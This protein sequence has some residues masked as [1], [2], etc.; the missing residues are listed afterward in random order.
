MSGVDEAGRL[1]RSVWIEGSHNP[2][3]REGKILRGDA[4]RRRQSVESRRVV[5][6]IPLDV[7]EGFAYGLVVEE[8]KYLVPP[9]RPADAS[10]ELVELIGVLRHGK[11]RAVESLVCVEARFVVRKEETAVEVV[12]AALGS[13]LNLGAAETAILGIVAVGNDFYALNGIFGRR[14][15]RCTAPDGTCGANAV[16]RNAIVFRLLT[17]GDDLCAVFGFKDAVRATGLPAACLC[18]WKIITVTSASTLRAI[19]EGSRSK[20][21]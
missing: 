19:R 21:R 16:D 15:D 14:D 3:A 18:A 20:F 11:A 4:S 8:E 1:A 6:T 10:A 13:N 5:P 9:D 2:I 17:I 12:R 7:G